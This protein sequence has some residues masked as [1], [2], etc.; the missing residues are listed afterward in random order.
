MT[1]VAVVAHAGKS[2][3]GGLVELRRVLEEAGVGDPLWYEV[4]KSRKAPKQVKRALEEGAELVFA[5]GGDGTVQRCI[6]V[7]AGTRIPLAIVP[8]GTANLLATNLGIP[9]DIAEAVETGLHGARRAIDVGRLNGERFGVMA[10]AGLDAAM[11]RDADAGLKDRVG[12]IAYVWTGAR[13]VTSKPFKAKIRVDGSTWFDD[14]TSCIL[15][16]NV[17]SLFGG[18]EAFDDARP[19]DGM[20]ELGVVT[21]E[22]PMQWAR[23]I[24]RTAVGHD[25]EVALRPG[26]ARPDDRGE[27]Q[28]E[29][30]LRAGRRRP[31]EGQ[32]V[33]DRGRARRDR[34]LRPGGV[35]STATR[36]PE[37][38]ELTGDD[39]RRTLLD[40]GRMRLVADAFARLRYADGFSHARSLAFM[41][42]LVFVQGLIALVGFAAAFGN[43]EVSRVIVD[44]IENAMP[45]LAGE[46]LTDAVQQAREVGA[47][48]RFLP[49]TLGLIG[50]IVTGTTAL[51]QVERAVNRIYGIERDRPA[52]EKYG[53]AFVL[54]LSV[55]FLFAV[56]FVLLA[57]G[58]DIGREDDLVHQIWTIVRWPAGLL[59][60]GL[61]L[62]G[63]LQYAPRRHQPNMS[64]LAFGA[65]IGVLLWTAVTFGFGLVFN[66]SS[67]FGETYGPLAGI[68]ALQLW[69]LFSAVAILFGVAVA[70]QLEAVRAGLSEPAEPD[71]EEHLAPQPAAATLANAQPS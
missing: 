66:A 56:A 65:G 2:V 23:T 60:A 26:H 49:L 8:A 40:T 53:R 63:L 5:W 28:P 30:A 10:G 29:G 7:L 24:A 27:A 71:P 54:A 43:L 44:T 48:N 15:V 46:I 18:V 42:S 69:S 32:V 35:V 62:T 12:R 6:D 20:L 36:V 59:I 3:G 39:A 51:G 13:N 47:H 58:R 25:R 17:G 68:V 11:I 33:R 38:W 41:M 50:T 14:K 52:L 55:G 1:R 9:D 19:D 64:W 34:D 57:F 37:T 61:A 21:A 16:G 67:S 22:S 4:P 31:R 70:A 45:G